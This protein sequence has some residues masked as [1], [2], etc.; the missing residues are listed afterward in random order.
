[1]FKFHPE[2]PSSGIM[3]S[4]KKALLAPLNPSIRWS[5]ALRQTED[6]NIPYATVDGRVNP[7]STLPL[8]H[9]VA[10]KMENSALEGTSISFKICGEDAAPD[11][12]DE[13]YERELP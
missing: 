11:T 8:P 2:V 4:K 9:W 10:E 6:S 12:S 7:Q 3:N 5:A 1:M 13:A